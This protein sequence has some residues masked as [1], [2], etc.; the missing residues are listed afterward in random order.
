MNKEEK[1]VISLASKNVGK[2]RSVKLEHKKAE[3]RRVNQNYRKLKQR[4]RE[5]TKKFKKL[6]CLRNEIKTDI[7]LLQCTSSSDSD[8]DDYEMDF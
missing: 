3:L 6:G 1:F 5:M 4:L 8:S 7:A 2:S